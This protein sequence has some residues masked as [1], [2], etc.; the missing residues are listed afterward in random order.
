MHAELCPAS[1][2]AE[3]SGVGMADGAV[4]VREESSEVDHK[5]VTLNS[6]RHLRG[7]LRCSRTAQHTAL[8]AWAWRRLPCR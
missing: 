2:Q 5:R 7:S 6:A 8:V 4:L 1:L 3:V